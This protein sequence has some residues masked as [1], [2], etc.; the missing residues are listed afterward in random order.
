MIRIRIWFNEY[1]W[2]EDH[3]PDADIVVEKRTKISDAVLRDLMDYVDS[4]MY[5]EDDCGG[6]HRIQ[7]ESITYL[8][9]NKYEVR[10]RKFY[11]HDKNYQPKEEQFDLPKK[12]NILLFLMER[13]RLFGED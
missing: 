11:G 5:G 4:H 8:K 2:E 3:D 10:Q 6:I 9:Q 1:S 12:Q 7:E 13:T